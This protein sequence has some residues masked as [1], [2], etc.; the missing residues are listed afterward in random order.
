[1]RHSNITC[2]H[3]PYTCR[4]GSSA[5]D[6]CRMLESRKLTVF[7]NTVRTDPKLL[8]VTEVH[9]RQIWMV[10]NMPWSKHV[11][12]LCIKRL[13]RQNTARLSIKSVL[14]NRIEFFDTWHVHKSVVR[15]CQHTVGILLCHL[16]M[17]YPITNHT[18]G[19]HPVHI[20]MPIVI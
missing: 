6:R 15:S 19:L 4:V 7:F 13:E 10:G 8:L 2:M 5:G 16:L 14:I 17:T 1:M 18:I 9:I 20:K 3:A 11:G 12:W